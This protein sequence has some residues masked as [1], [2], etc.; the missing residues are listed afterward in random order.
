MCNDERAEGGKAVDAIEGG[1]R[2]GEQ[3]AGEGGVGGLVLG[4]EGG[5]G[6]GGGGLSGSLAGCY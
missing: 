6:L 1:V 2:I 5:T 3:R 4:G